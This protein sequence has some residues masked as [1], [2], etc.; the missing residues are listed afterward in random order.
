MTNLVL[1]K[2]RLHQGVW[3]GVL[4][5]AAQDA[6]P[7]LSVTHQGRDVPEVRVTALAPPAGH[8]VHIRIPPEAIADGLHSLLIAD[9]ATGTTLGAITLM[10]GEALGDDMRAELDLLRAELDLL[11]RAF[12]RHCVETS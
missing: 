2:T 9:A 8:A 5:G 3:E 12:R 7:Q 6:V 11:K 1:T 4:T 10:A